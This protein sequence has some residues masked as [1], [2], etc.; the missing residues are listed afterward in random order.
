MKFRYLILAMAALSVAPL[1]PS[2]TYSQMVTRQEDGMVTLNRAL[3]NV[4]D[5]TTADAAAPAVRQ[6]GSLLRQDIVTLFSNGRPS[7]MQ[8]LL[9]KNSYQNSNLK[10]ESKTAL[11]EFFRIYSQSF[12]GSEELRQSFI[13]MLKAPATNTQAPASTPTAS[14]TGTTPGISP[15]LA[16]ILKGLFATSR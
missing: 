1:L 10:A 6:Y 2:C 12:Y 15:T 14:P 16:P 11:R 5:K 4:H 13:D 3:A 8:L 9:L 7:L